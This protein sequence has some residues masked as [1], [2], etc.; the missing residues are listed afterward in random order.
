MK[1]QEAKTEGQMGGTAGEVAVV[2]VPL[3]A[4]GNLNLLL[5]LSRLIA[6]HDVP[7]YYTGAATHIR[8]AQH[9]LQGWSPHSVSTLHFHAFP[10]P[11]FDSPDPDPTLRSPAHLLPSFRAALLLREPLREFLMDLSRTARRVVVIY[12]FWM[13][14]NVQDVP[15]VPNTESYAFRSTS[16]LSTLSFNWEMMKKE[17]LSP[18]PPEVSQV[19]KHLPDLDSSSSST[20]EVSELDKLQLEA[21]QFNSGTIFNTCEVLEGTFLDLLATDDR[22]MGPMQWAIGPFNPIILQCAAAAAAE[23]SRHPCLSWL[24]QQEKNSVIF[25]SFGS[26]ITLPQE[27]INEIAVG[28]EKSGHKFIWA[29]R[30]ADKGDIFA[31]EEKRVALPDGYEEEIKGKGMAVRDWVPQLEILAHPS[32]GGFLS[33]C[34]WNSCVEAISMGVPIAAW[35]VHSDQPRNAALITEVLKVGFEVDGGGCGGRG[36]VRSGRIREAVLRLM[37]CTEGDEMR[38]RAEELSRAVKL[39][40]LD[41][42]GASRKEMDSFLSHI[43]RE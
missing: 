43:T 19:L 16:A 29:A 5:H 40:V 42:G 30:E 32:T 37:G 35:P 22:L 33:H 13:A 10:T 26:T 27:Q 1:G 14:W 21:P 18:L 24:D 7:V 11:S 2:M 36:V 28:L 6:S 23:S 15:S 38:R 41:R 17:K 4:Q 34:G 12:D 20:Q 31:G 3:P 9:R 25:V 8:Q 39:S